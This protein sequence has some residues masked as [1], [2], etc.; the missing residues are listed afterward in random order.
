MINDNLIIHNSNNKDEDGFPINANGSQIAL[1]DSEGN[2][3]IPIQSN[4][5]INVIEN[6]VI[7]FNPNDPLES[8]RAFDN[9]VEILT[10]DFL[11]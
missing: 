3:L 6:G 10:K 8:R 11:Y 2:V 9:L 5:F 7:K 4:F 1:L